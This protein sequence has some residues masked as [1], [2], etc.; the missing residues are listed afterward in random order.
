M[1][2]YDLGGNFLQES[3][4]IE[5]VAVG[6]IMHLLQQS[7][8]EL[9][10]LVEAESTGGEE[11]FSDIGSPLPGVGVEREESV[12]LCNSIGG[13]YCV[14]G[15]NVLGEHCLELFLLDIPL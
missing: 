3:L 15:A 9:V 12:K 6:R 4:E 10:F 8:H 11:E 13:E 2:R 1:E 14:F 7:E 5:G